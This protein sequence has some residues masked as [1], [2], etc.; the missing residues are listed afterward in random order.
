MRASSQHPD[1]HNV[2]QCAL[3]LDAEIQLL[4]CTEHI[5]MKKP[6]SS[7]IQQWQNNLF[8]FGKLM[9][10]TSDAEITTKIYRLMRQ[11]KEESLRHGCIRRSST[12]QSE[13]ANKK[14]K[15]AYSRTKNSWIQSVC[16]Y[17]WEKFIHTKL[18]T[19]AIL[20]VQTKTMIYQTM[21]RLAKNGLLFFSLPLIR[22]M[23]CK[24]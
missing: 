13:R 7:E 23:K 19:A 24:D 16:S 3:T 21:N 17:F 22:L 4:S 14:Y 9:S 10:E 6:N 1:E 5:R 11:V 15:I 12:E 2:L 20:N 8:N 18:W